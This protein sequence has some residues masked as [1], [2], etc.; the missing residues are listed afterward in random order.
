MTVEERSKE[1]IYSKVMNDK[2]Y[3]KF[4]SQRQIPWY[5]W[6]I[7][8]HSNNWLKRNHLPMA[9][10]KKRN[11]IRNNVIHD[12]IFFNIMENTIDD[13]LLEGLTDTSLF[14]KFVDVKDEDW[15]YDGNNRSKDCPPE[16]KDEEDLQKSFRGKRSNIIYVW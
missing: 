15:V 8:F 4:Q 13:I 9:T 11:Y 14:G 5:K 12:G 16:I 2:I 10:K 3:S 1:L 6:C 7:F